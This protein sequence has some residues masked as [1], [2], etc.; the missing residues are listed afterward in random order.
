MSRGPGTWQRAILG[1]A[2][3]GLATTVRAIVLD[4]VPQPTRSDYVSARRATKTLAL[5]GRVSAVYLHACPSCGAPQRAHPHGCC[6]STRPLLGIT[7]VGSRPPS[8]APPPVSQVPGGISA[9][10]AS[11]PL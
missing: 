3:D 8:L 11:T 6:A 9:A 7:P 5:S 4:C 2:G 1:I 10:P